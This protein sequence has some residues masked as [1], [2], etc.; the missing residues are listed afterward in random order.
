MITPTPA[1]CSG[2]IPEPFYPRGRAGRSH[3]EPKPFTPPIQVQG[4]DVTITDAGNSILTT[5]DGR[6][7]PVTVEEYKEKLAGELVAHAPTLDAFRA[8]WIDPA[9]RRDLLAALPDGARSALLVRSSMTRS[10]RSVRRAGPPGLRTGPRTRLERAAAFTYKHAAW[11]G[12]MPRAAPRLCAP[13]P[14][15][16]AAPAPTASRTAGL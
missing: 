1:G 4:F 11:L 6:A 16:S 5:V 14:C 15:S 3:P 12:T 13:W 8:M 7:M 2:R 9:S 10:L